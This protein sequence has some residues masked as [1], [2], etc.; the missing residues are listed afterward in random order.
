MNDGTVPT[1]LVSVHTLSFHNNPMAVP[2]YTT[3]N[4]LKVVDLTYPD[5]CTSIL[6]LLQVRLFRQ[7]HNCTS[8]NVLYL[9]CGEEE[10][11][12]RPAYTPVP[13]R[14]IGGSQ[15]APGVWPWHVQILVNGKYQCGGSLVRDAFDKHSEVYITD[16]LLVLFPPPPTPCFWFSS[17]WCVALRYK[18]D[19][20]LPY[21]AI[22]QY[23]YRFK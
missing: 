1:T 12:R 7:S 8:G 16:R 22:E 10:C 21:K 23:I 18:I 3:V 6:L 5:P 14:I 17:S 11:G 13:S 9:N 19:D 4:I 15:S 20:F 2:V